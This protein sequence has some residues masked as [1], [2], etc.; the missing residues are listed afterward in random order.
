MSEIAQTSVRVQPD[1]HYVKWFLRETSVIKGVEG[2]HKQTLNLLYT[3][4]CVEWHRFKLYWLLADIS[5]YE[6]TWILSTCS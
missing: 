6:V 4:T 2:S 3:Q 5:F 1:S